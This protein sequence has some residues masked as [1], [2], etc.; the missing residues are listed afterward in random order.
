MERLTAALGAVLRGVARSL[1][2]ERRDWA[3]AVQAEASMLPAGRARLGWLAGGLWLVAREAHL[4]RKII[5]VLGT[6]AIAVLA[7]WAVWQSW[8]TAPGAQ[9][10]NERLRIMVAVAA[11]LVL[12]WVGRGHGW[13][14]PVG[15]TVTARLLRLAGCAAI[16]RLGIEVVQFGGP[17]GVGVT[18]AFSWPREIAGL[19]LLGGVLSA[20]TVLRARWPRAEGT[21]LWTFTVIMAT[22]AF[23]VLPV[24][25]LTVGY[26][27]ALL[28]ATAK[29]SP[30]R[31]A[32][33]VAG[34]ATGLVAGA[35][36]FGIE[37]M[38]HSDGIGALLLLV[39]IPAITA[40]AATAGLVAAWRCAGSASAAELRSAQIRHGLFAGVLAG[41]VA[42]LLPALDFGV[43]SR[44]SPL[45]VTVALVTGPLAGLAGGLAGAAHA[46]DHPRRERP[47][48]FRGAGA[49]HRG[50]LAAR[51]VRSRSASRTAGPSAW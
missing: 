33:I 6:G 2:P 49:V 39:V 17:Y 20:P 26:I 38:P 48:G 28:A 3:E 24:Q 11:F 42:G 27:G 37:R 8:R 21:T 16:C 25:L 31:P 7:A 1:P 41:A 19:V 44:L 23:A 12:P 51:R 29:R 13:F 14:G 22:V 9:V 4:V 45:G 40:L 10:M 32:D 5:Y 34:A 47:D 46:A 15:D 30:V 50:V 43:L 35:V 18:P 36:A